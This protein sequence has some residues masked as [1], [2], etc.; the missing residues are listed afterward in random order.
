VNIRRQRRSR[1]ITLTV[2]DTEH[3]EITRRARAHRVP[4]AAYVRAAALSRADDPRGVAVDADRWWGRLP[5]GRKS[6][7]MSWLTAS[8]GPDPQWPA[9]FD[10]DQVEIVEVMGC[11]D[12]EPRAI[13]VK[14]GDQP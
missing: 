10:V 9:L 5:P 13:L 1:R 2:D 12:T 8:S 4:V 7:I 6:Q 11:G 14:K 3:R